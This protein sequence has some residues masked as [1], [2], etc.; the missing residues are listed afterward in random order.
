MYFD[1]P[2]AYIRR[3]SAFLIQSSPSTARRPAGPLSPRVCLGLTSTPWRPEV[4]KCAISEI[5]HLP[6]LRATVCSAVVHALVLPVFLKHIWH[7]Q[8]NGAEIS[9]GFNTSKQFANSTNNNV[10]RYGT[11]WNNNN[12]DIELK[13]AI[14]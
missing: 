11:T 4:Q 3:P 8:T 14:V 2:E 7:W 6:T 12:E 9:L 13:V 1:L 10:R 5:C